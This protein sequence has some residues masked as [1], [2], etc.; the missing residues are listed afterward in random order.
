MDPAEAV[1]AHRTLGAAHSVAGIHFG[2]FQL[3][4]EW[5]DR[6]VFELER[7][8]AQLHLDPEEFVVLEGNLECPSATIP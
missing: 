3:T 5:I 8:A 7:A 6:P 4:D 1:Q 2:T